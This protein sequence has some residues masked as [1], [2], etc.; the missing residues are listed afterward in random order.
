MKIKLNISDLEVILTSF[1]YSKN[2]ISEYQ[3]P[4][5]IASDAYK[6]RNRRIEEINVVESK[7][8]ELK[9]ELKKTN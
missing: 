4:E 8:Y 7:I 2:R 1:K 9:R 3:Y 6:L 5:I